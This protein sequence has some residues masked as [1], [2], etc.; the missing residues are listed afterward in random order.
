M[1]GNNRASK[2]ITWRKAFVYLS[3]I[4]LIACADPK[5]LTFWVGVSLVILAWLLRLW[6]FGYLDK[7]ALMVTTGPYAY[8]RNPAYLGSFIAL[9]GI[10]LAAGNWDTERGRTVWVFALLLC[11]VFFLIYLPRKMKRE[12]PRLRALFGV[13]LDRHAENVPNFFPR[14]T[15]WKSGQSR[16]YSF[17]LLLENHEVSWGVAFAFA[18]VAIKFVHK[19][20]PFV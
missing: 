6:A 13:E 7:N 4:A 16:K 3:S 1:S 15:P 20:S 8:T 19:W 17:S 18:L 14:L 2:A 12:Y 10:S 9:L 11:F 5:E